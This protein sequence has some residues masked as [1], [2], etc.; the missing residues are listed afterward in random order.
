M[1]SLLFGLLAGSVVM[2]SSQSASAYDRRIKVIN[3]TGYAMTGLYAS[4]TSKRNWNYNMLQNGGIAPGDFVIADVDEGSGFCMYD[5]L[6]VF[7]DGT[8][9]PRYQVDAC[10]LGTWTIN[11]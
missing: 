1:K 2:L 4:N 3:N 6:A 10:T 8:R 7:E 11:E 5:L 9:V